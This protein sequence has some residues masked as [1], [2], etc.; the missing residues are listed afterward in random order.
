MIFAGGRSSRMGPGQPKPLLCIGERSM[1]GRVADRL[2]PHVAEL[3]VATDR[4]DLYAGLDAGCLR[5]HVPGYAGPLAGLQT[6]A[7]HALATQS[8]DARLLS[9][10]SDTP[11]L[12]EDFVPRLLGGTR[13]ERLRVA[14]SSG[15]LH[16]V[17]ALWPAVALEFLADQHL[18]AQAAPSLRSVMERFDVE[19]VPFPSSPAAPG[20]DPFFNVNTPDDLGLAR[21]FALS[22]G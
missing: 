21:E 4:P 3:L 8:R 19:E 15:R 18:D 1:I 13:S 22:R 12:P 9:A 17:C 11:F 20:G 2:R 7:R 10:P 5:D 6:G 16:P 14:S